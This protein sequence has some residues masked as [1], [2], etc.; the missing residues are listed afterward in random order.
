[1]KYAGATELLVLCSKFYVVIE[2]IVEAVVFRIYIMGFICNIMGFICKVG[3]DGTGKSRNQWN[4][5]DSK[6]NRLN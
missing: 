2:W 5:N 6:R 3:P 1:L 4:P